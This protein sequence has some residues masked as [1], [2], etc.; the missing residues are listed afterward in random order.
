MEYDAII[1]NGTIYDGRGGAPFQGD[2][3]IQGELIAGV[4]KLEG[5]KGRLEIDAS[6]L[7]IA[8]GVGKL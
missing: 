1:R 4:G 6:D 3:A 2:V 5:D 8:P 7:A